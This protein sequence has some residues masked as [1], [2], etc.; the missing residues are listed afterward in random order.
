MSGP[1]RRR[2]GWSG[3]RPL[4]ADED[5]S[6]RPLSESLD[7]ISRS[8]GVPGAA[9]LGVLFSRWD[10]I[11][12]PVAASHSWP[13]SVTRDALVV[14]VDGPGWATSLRAL[15]AQL[16]KRVEDVAGP[17]VAERVEVRVKPRD[18]RPSDTPVVD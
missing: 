2:S 18:Q 16:L 8:M 17:G 5:R 1:S 12:G 3:W 6:P 11:A 9:A 14:A 13:I 4:A 7:H 15:S 10:E